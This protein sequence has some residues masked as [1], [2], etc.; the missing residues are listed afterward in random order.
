MQGRG[1]CF[2]EKNMIILT[3]K[4]SAILTFRFQIKMW[5]NLRK[6]CFHSKWQ[7]KKNH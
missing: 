6:M 4:N 1:Y 7:L 5:V 3:K 2:I